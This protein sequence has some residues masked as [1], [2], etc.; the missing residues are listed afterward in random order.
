MSRKFIKVTAIEC[1]S[2]G[3]IGTG[4]TTPTELYLH[5]D[6]IGAFKGNDVY[7]KAGSFI[8]VGGHYYTKLKL[9]EG[10]QVPE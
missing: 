1:N 10:Q 3:H 7:L 8:A 5:C 2:Q 4:H 6:L 9:A